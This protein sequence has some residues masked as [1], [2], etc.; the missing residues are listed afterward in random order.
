MSQML[1]LGISSSLHPHVQPTVLIWVLL[2][3]PLLRAGCLHVN[4]L[5]LETE[6]LLLKYFYSL[7]TAHNC[8]DQ[9]KHL[10]K[11]AEK[12]NKAT[13][14]LS[15]NFYRQQHLSKTCSHKQ[16]HTTVCMF[17]HTQLAGTTWVHSSEWCYLTTSPD[18]LEHFF[19]LWTHSLNALKFSNLH[20]TVRNYWWGVLN[21]KYQGCL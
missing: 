15:R 18:P 16:A 5:S 19:L 14:E 6:F 20:S 7:C 2:Q 11:R 9:L 13:K 1:G 21:S 12:E 17:T 8:T 4:N 10:L 3:K